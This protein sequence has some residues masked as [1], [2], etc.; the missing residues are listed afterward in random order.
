MIDPLVRLAANAEPGS[1]RFVLLAG[2][3]VSRDS[4][5][6]TAWD[7]LL[8]TAERLRAAEDPESTT[9]IAD[10]FAA[11]RYSALPYADMVGA[12]YPHSGEQRA[13]LDA[14]LTRRDPGPAQLLIAELAKRA[15]LRAIITPNFDDLLEKAAARVG[16]EVEVIANERTFAECT[17]LAHTNRLRIYKPHGTLGMRLRNTPAEVDELPE[18]ITSELSRVFEDHSIV[19]LGYAGNE[20]GLMRALLARRRNIYPVYWLHMEPDLPAAAAA[21]GEQVVPIRINGGAGAALQ[22]ILQVQD[23]LARRTAARGRLDSG[24]V[25]EAISADRKDAAARVRS[26]CREHEMAVRALA[27]RIQDMNWNVNPTADE[28]FLQALTLTEPLT[29]AFLEVARAAAEFGEVQSCI[30]LRQY[31][32]KLTPTLCPVGAAVTC[33]DFPAFLAQEMFGGLIALLV[34]EN[35]WEVLRATLAYDYVDDNGDL[36]GW[37]QLGA[38]IAILDEWRKRRVDSRQFTL[39]GDEYRA[40]FQ[41]PPISEVCSLSELEDADWLLAFIPYFQADPP[42][43]HHGGAW[44]PRMTIVSDRTP[45]WLAKM[46]SNS[47][48]APLLEI[49]MPAV[50]ASARAERFRAHLPEACSIGREIWRGGLVRPLAHYQRNLQN[51]LFRRP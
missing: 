35:R 6:P 30:A 29:A 24:S 40:R 15:V 44:F 31:I 21:L 37:A 5:Q 12:V 51:E 4:G 18:T 38:H 34:R 45:A 16:I 19:V 39:A 17:P 43:L 1:K 50:E 7:L 22:T 32:H 28:G 3:G 25:I 41:R 47:F 36:V 10:W 20:A 23:S 48:A 49:M 42:G 13:F 11:S 2:A 33:Q 9:P 46:R 14:Q 8:N 26:F 27:P